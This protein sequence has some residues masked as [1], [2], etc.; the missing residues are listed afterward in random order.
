[1]HNPP[2]ASTRRRT[3]FIFRNSVPFRAAATPKRPTRE[4]IT[5]WTTWSLFLT[6]LCCIVLG[7]GV[8]TT[9]NYCIMA[10]T[11][12]PILITLGIG[13]IPAG[14]YGQSHKIGERIREH[15]AQSASRQHQTQDSVLCRIF[16]VIPFL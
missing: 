3:G 12:A 2:P 7:M 1:M 16:P 15:H 9:A 11:C 5:I 10:S 6:M 14:Y 8:P 13:K 4:V